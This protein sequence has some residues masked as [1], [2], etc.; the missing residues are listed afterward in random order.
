MRDLGTLAGGSSSDGYGINNFGKVVGAS[1]DGTGWRAFRYDG[2]P[3]SGG[4]MR[5]L[6]SLGGNFSRA[7][8]INDAGFVVG[9]AE[10][11]TGSSV[12]ALW[13]PDL[14]IIDLEAWLD[15]VNP[16]QGAYWRLDYALSVN[17]AGLIVGSG[18][19][20]DGYGS[21]VLD[22]S[23]LVPEPAGLVLLAL[24]TPMMLCRERCRQAVP[25]RRDV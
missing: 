20:Q 9:S 14:S 23:S 6:G 24:L 8:D 21:F 16:A 7:D 10:R 2:T 22:A 18:S 11:D 15:A 19:H 1:D 12:A 3:G 13:R 5:E 4:I 17:D 25:S